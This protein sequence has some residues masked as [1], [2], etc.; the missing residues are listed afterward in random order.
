VVADN[1]PDGADVERT[2]AEDSSYAVLAADLGFTD[3]DAGQTL[4]AV[5][6]DSL[7]ANGR[8]T[9]NGADV[10]AGQVI[11]VAALDAGQLRLVPDADE[12]GSPY[13]SFTF[14]VQDS[15]GRF[16]T[17]PNTF[18]LNVTPVNDDPLARPD[19]K[20]T[21]EDTLATG[22]VLDNDSDIDSPT[23]TVVSYTVDGQS[24]VAGVSAVLPQGALTINPDGSYTFQPRADYFGP[25]P[26]ATYTVRDGQGGTATSTLTIEVTPVNDPP[27]D[28][29]EVNTVTEDVVLIVTDGAEGDLL[30]NASDIDGDALTITGF[31][32]DGI[33][34]TQAVGTPVTIPD[35]GV[36]TLNADG[37]YSFE[38]ATDYIGAVPTITYTVDD[39]HG[40][41]DSSTLRLSVMPQNDDPVD[42]DEVNIVT[43]DTTLVVAAGSPQN[44]LANAADADGDAL[45]ITGY[46]VAGL[47]GPQVLGAPVLIAGI[48]T[49]TIQANGSYSFTPAADYNGPVPLITYAVG[50]G[51]G[52]TDTSTL[53]LTV[54][55]ANDPPIGTPDLN[56][57]VEGTVLTGNVIFNDSDPEGDSLSVLRFSLPGLGNF[58]AGAAAQIAGI[59]TLVI[60]ANGDYRFTPVAGFVGAVPVATYVLS[61]GQAEASTTL[62]L[63]YTM[64]NRA[65]TVADVAV[66]LSEE[67]LAAGLADANG[68]P[69]TTDA[70]TL[71]GTLV[72]SDANGDPITVTLESPVQ[73]YTSGG[74][75]I[76]WS[77]SGSATLIGSAGGVE[78]IRASVASG[79]YSVTLGGPIDH[80]VQG[81][82]DA[83]TLALGLRVS[84]GVA[85][86]T[87]RLNVTLE[88]DAP[89]AASIEQAVPDG[90]QN[91]NILLVLDVSGSMTDDSGVF[92][93]A[94][95]RTLTRLEL[96]EQA[97]DRLL[98]AYDAQGN[99][100]VRIVTFSTNA[101]PVGGEWTDVATARAQLAGIVAGGFTNYDEALTDAMDAF[102]SAGKLELAQNV[103]YFLSDGNPNTPDGVNFNTPDDGIQADEEAAWRAFLA[104]NGMN[105]FALGLGGAGVTQANLNPVAYDGATLA[106]TDG[107]VV[108][109]LLQLSD[110]LAQTVEQS[111]TGRLGLATDAAAANAFGADGGHVG[112]I[113]LDGT[114][115]SYDPSNGGS[116]SVVGTDAGRYDPATHSLRIV[117][118][119]GGVF[120]VDLDD[121]A[122]RYAAPSQAVVGGDQIG[123]VL[124]DGDG[125]TASGT[126]TLQATGGPSLQRV[127]EGGNDVVADVF[128]WALADAGSAGQPAELQADGFVPGRDTLDLHDLLVGEASGGGIGNL[129]DYLSFRSGAD[130]TEVL[131]SSQGGF[132][133][134]DYLAA[135]HDTTLVLGADLVAGLGLAAG[136]GD[137]QILGELLRAGKLVVDQA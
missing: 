32:I 56:A 8:L 23:L 66:S 129:E 87:G 123:F 105:S 69:D 126:L 57:G 29:D 50:D 45:S 82:E 91:T 26:V 27:V 21:P 59:G 84:D 58:A 68:T 67:G 92:D 76:T 42:G 14:S 72:T 77:G 104:A 20:S 16:D 13:A 107:V 118:L 30:N 35:V 2:I 25:V 136:A 98:D 78:I 63:S 40:G 74:V 121:G 3:A 52:G 71:S 137:A 6:I 41:N 114:V 88:D 89:V 10:V 1:P 133:G 7:P 54:V 96:Q 5:R 18:V 132:T 11:A 93:S 110:V 102:A 28:G 37:S 19:L 80:P 33:D 94:L 112:S 108:T 106:D 115:Y 79:G 131:I 117:A 125:D 53:R 120:Q 81:A 101:E 100:Q 95:G 22:N 34:G 73:A 39:G 116:V 83:L 62:T 99:V 49:L 113:S 15:T 75:A 24:L 51:Q 103:T 4:A 111:S 128:H 97:I 130:G 85:S 36:I 12:S 31:S 46:S 65:P 61:D 55:P 134:G 124:V 44:L 70:I 17:A 119:S 90:T 38:P 47:A 64:G 43:E 109:N 9:L 86:S 135:A 60:E 48:G 127:A 122:Y